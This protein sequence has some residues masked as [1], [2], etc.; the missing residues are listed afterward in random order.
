MPVRV[1]HE[2]LERA[3]RLT[4]SNN[5]LD[6]NAGGVQLLGKLMDSP[7][8]VLIGF[9]VNVGFGSWKLNCGEAGGLRRWL[10]THAAG[11]QALPKSSDA[12]Q[13][14][15]LVSEVFTQADRGEERTRVASGGGGFASA[16]SSHGPLS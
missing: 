13:R 12:E 14:A 11:R 8:W 10:N 15:E 5:P 4:C 2:S 1:M 3:D 6:F 7:V 9:R 16:S